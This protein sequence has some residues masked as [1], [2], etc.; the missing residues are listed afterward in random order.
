[1]K[2]KIKKETLILV[3]VSFGYLLSELDDV[4]VSD[5]SGLPK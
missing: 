5:V 2:N 3:K 4:S 1:M